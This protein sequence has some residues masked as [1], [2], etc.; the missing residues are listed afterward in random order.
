MGRFIVLWGSSIPSQDMFGRLWLWGAVRM[1]S[2]KSTET[3]PKPCFMS[4]SQLVF[5]EPGPL[6][7][8]GGLTD[9]SNRAF[10]CIRRESDS[11]LAVC[12]CSVMLF[13]L[14]ARE[15]GS[16][17][18][19][20]STPRPSRWFRLWLNIA[21]PKNHWIND[22]LFLGYVLFCLVRPSRCDWS[23]FE[24]LLLFFSASLNGITAGRWELS[25]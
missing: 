22:T 16:I 7:D 8:L 4:T 19:Q 14:K 18:K 6:R 24:P 2:N 3:T 10:N 25:D 11:I 5:Y 12:S 1:F 9:M 20:S 13:S 17:S 21:F 15:G 23:D